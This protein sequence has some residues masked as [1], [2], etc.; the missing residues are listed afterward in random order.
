MG[1]NSDYSNIFEAKIMIFDFDGVIIDSMNVK[2]NEYKLLFSQFTKEETIL[3]E[4]VGIYKNSIGIP[5]EITLKKVFNDFLNKNLTEQE[6]EDL[7]LAY[8]KAIFRRLE[9]AKPLGGFL[10][11]LTLHKEINKHII[12]GA[13]HSD[14]VFL[15]NKLKLSQHFKSI[16]G[17]PLDKKNEIIGIK[18]FEGVKGKEMVYFGDQKNDFIAARAAGVQ[19]VGINASQDLAITQ[20]RVFSDFHELINYEIHGG[21]CTQK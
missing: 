5:R 3:N 7:S 21:L 12:S 17:G 4:I 11:Y 10:E 20:H 15:A 2:T 14:I 19:F 18:N 9:T 6:V 13:P 1:L 8:S 16:K